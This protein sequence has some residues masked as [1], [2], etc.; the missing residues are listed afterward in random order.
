[1]PAKKYIELLN[2]KLKQKV[3]TIVSA[4]AG[5]EGD[6]VA[7]DAAGKI[8][9]S[10]LPVGVGP[11]VSLIV[12]SEAIGAGKYVNIFNDAGIPKVRLADNT[13]SR[14][15]HGFLKDAAALAA[16]AVVYFE[17]P[18]DDF[19]ALTVGARQYLSTAG[20]VTETPPTAAGGAAISQ[21]VG[22]AVNATTINTDAEDQIGLA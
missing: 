18:N 10:V 22:Y 17:G 11:D 19:S 9:V 21:L 3:A 5:N 15:A 13:N 20:G 2:G 4:G 8:D 6:L 12:T 1:M 16:T 7:L 14:E